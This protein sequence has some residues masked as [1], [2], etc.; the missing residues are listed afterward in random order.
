MS[1]AASQRATAASCWTPSDCIFWDWWSYRKYWPDWLGLHLAREVLNLCPSPLRSGRLRGEILLFPICSFLRFFP[2][3]AEAR[4]LWSSVTIN[5]IAVPFGSPDRRTGGI[6]TFRIFSFLV[7]LLN[8][9][10]E[11]PSPS[12]FKNVGT[13]N[14]SPCSDVTSDHRQKHQNTTHWSWN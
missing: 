8:T 14:R 6:A 13:E 7:L 4:R 1:L 3:K 10:G 2:L 12:R 11:S 5:Y 9:A